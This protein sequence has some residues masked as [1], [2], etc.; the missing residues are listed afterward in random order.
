MTK[1][2]VWGFGLALVVSSAI[3][4]AQSPVQRVERLPAFGNNAASDDDTTAIVANPANLAFLPGSEFRWS[5]AYL[6]ESAGVNWQGHALAFGL[7][8]GFLPLGTALRY[9]F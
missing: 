9:D 4:A 6:D 8:L 3:A 7:P 5:S 2:A 1:S